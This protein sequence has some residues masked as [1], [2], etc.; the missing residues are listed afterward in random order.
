MTFYKSL[1]KSLLEIFNRKA[2]EI[3]VF[4]HHQVVSNLVGLKIHY[5]VTFFTHEKKMFTKIV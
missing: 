1:L 4:F 2:K 3:N 5:P